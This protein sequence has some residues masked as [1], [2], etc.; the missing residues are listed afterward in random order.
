MRSLDPMTFFHQT[1]ISRT[2]RKVPI[3]KKLAERWWHRR[4]SK[5]FNESF[6][7]FQKLESKARVTDSSLQ[8]PNRQDV[9]DGASLIEAGNEFSETIMQWSTSS[10]FH[11]LGYQDLYPVILNHL[12]GEDARVLEI[13]I[14]V[15]DPR[16]ASGMDKDHVPGGSLYA[17]KMYLNAAEVH[18]AD[19]DARV[20]IDTEMY[21]THH[22][23]QRNRDSLVGLAD[24][25]DGEL[26]LFIDDGLHTPQANALTACAFL[27]RISDR[28][29]LVIEDILPEFNK[30]WEAL[31]KS[32]TGDFR[33]RFFPGADLR[34]GRLEG[35][36]I[37]WRV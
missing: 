14:G 32:F 37:F 30:L 31:E 22:V 4:Q 33:M 19:I 10:K 13:G 17:W 15:N 25:I 6:R 2:V 11:S 8:I 12:K 16:A 35:I 5:A 27:P 20:L 1:R 24:R 26:D 34:S 36:A 29:V 7:R 21:L 23:D 9:R 28:G 3:V 18:G